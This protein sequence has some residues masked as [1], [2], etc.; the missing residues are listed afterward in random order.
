MPVDLRT[1]GRNLGDISVDNLTI[2]QDL[3]GNIGGTPTWT[4]QHIFDGGINLSE[5]TL[6]LGGNDYN[7]I[8]TDGSLA[9]YSGHNRLELRTYYGPDEEWITDLQTQYG[10]VEI[11]NGNL[12]LDTGQSIEDGSGTSRIRLLGTET[13]FLQS[14]GTNESYLRLREN[15]YARFYLTEGTPFQLRDENGGF[16]ALEYQTSSS[17]PGTLELTNA[18]LDASESDKMSLPQTTSDPTASAG[19]MWYRTD[20]D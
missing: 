8:Q 4:S 3:I 20:L 17:A 2:E 14:G 10:D 1:L 5:N 15:S 19:D 16:T 6:M 11:P 7:R 18:N 13:Q 12:R 9:I